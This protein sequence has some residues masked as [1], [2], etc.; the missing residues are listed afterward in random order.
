MNI[1]NQKYKV[2]KPY[3]QIHKLNAY[4]IGFYFHPKGI[5]KMYQGEK[6]VSFS[7]VIDGGIV[8]EQTISEIKKPFTERQLILRASKFIKT[9]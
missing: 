1:Y 4:L 8:K 7:I 6:F 9:L 5:V 3:S 2:G